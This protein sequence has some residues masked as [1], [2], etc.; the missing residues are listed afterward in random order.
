MIR[1]YFKITI[2]NLLKN[3]TFSAINILGLSLGLT[4]C[5]LIAAY[6]VYETGYDRF[7]ENYKILY[8]VAQHQDQNGIWYKVGRTPIKLAPTLNTEFP[9]VENATR[10]AMWGNVLLSNEDK[11]LDEP[12]A[13]Y[14]ESALLKCLASHL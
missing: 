9:E 12:G 2:R 4:V 14:A 8:R 7:N 11:S 10:F 1:N 3:K 5:L 6:V 13:I